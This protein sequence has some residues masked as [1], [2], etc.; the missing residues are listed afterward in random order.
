MASN[1]AFA[2]AI[3]SENHKSPG[4]SPQF[5][6]VAL[7]NDEASGE[8]Y[9]QV[10]FIDV[11]RCQKEIRVPRDELDLRPML[12][13]RLQRHGAYF[14]DDDS[15]N[16]QAFAQYRSTLNNPQR[17][18]VAKATGWRTE[19]HKAFVT[20]SSVVGRSQKLIRSPSVSIPINLPWHPCKLAQ[21]CGD[22]CGLFEQ[23][24]YLHSRWFGSAVVRL[25]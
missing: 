8:F 3:A 25:C 10:E 22:T 7:G 14:S 12:F 24:G 17:F 18:T 16:D 15:I 23:N 9:G 4:L 19:E 13:K 21:A 6:L 2:I 20:N 11:D 1:K 5:R